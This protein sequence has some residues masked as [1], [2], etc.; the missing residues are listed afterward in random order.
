MA[1]A[2]A[3]QRAPKAPAFSASQR[4]G[5]DYA[6]GRMVIQAVLNA[7][8]RNCL[9]RCHICVSQTMAEGSI[10]RKESAPGSCSAL[11]ICG[12]KPIRHGLPF[13]AV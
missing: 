7:S 3:I 1:I 4:L 2:H 6:R 8:L 10:S 13:P 11:E 5:K 9:A 12:D